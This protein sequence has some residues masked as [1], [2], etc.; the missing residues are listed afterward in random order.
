[1]TITTN[2]ATIFQFQPDSGASRGVRTLTLDGEPWFVAKDIC[3]V[4]GYTNAADAVARH[5]KGI[6]KRDTLT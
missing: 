2:I 3:D 5:C 6:A 1:M 4:L